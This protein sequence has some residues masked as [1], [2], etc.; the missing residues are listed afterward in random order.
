MEYRQLGRSGL[1]VSLHTLG[2]MT[3]GGEGFFGKIGAAGVKDGKRLVDVCVDHGVNLLDTSN[4]YSFGKSEEILGEILKGA[5][6][7]LMVATKVRFGM[8]STASRDPRVTHGGMMR[9]SSSR[10]WPSAR[11]SSTR[12]ASASP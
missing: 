5:S 3:F 6:S 1:K 9:R 10:W 11:A 8:G 7:Q 12:P 2:T 4:I